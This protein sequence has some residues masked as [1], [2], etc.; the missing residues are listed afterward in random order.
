MHVNSHLYF[1]LRVKY[2]FFLKKREFVRVLSFGGGRTTPLGLAT[3]KG[4]NLSLS[5]SSRFTSSTTKDSDLRPRIT[6][7]DLE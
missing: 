7:Q 2:F 1:K 3:P 5:L 4:Q 6:N